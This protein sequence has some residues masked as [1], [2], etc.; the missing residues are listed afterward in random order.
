MLDCPESV[1]VQADEGGRTGMGAEDN[2]AAIRT[3]YEAFG[4]G[5]VEA[6]LTAVADDV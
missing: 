2:L 1:L 4:T 5:D 3:I 6:I